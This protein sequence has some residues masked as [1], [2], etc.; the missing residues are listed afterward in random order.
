MGCPS[1][2]MPSG[3]INREH[4]PSTTSLGR[5]GGSRSMTVP[6]IAAP[7]VMRGRRTFIT[8]PQGTESYHGLSCFSKDVLFN[9][10]KP[11][12]LG[13]TLGVEDSDLEHAVADAV[14]SFLTELPAKIQA[15]SGKYGHD[16]RTTATINS[17]LMNTLIPKGVNVQKVNLP[18]I[19]R[20]CARYFRK[21]GQ[22]WY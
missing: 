6:S 13:A 10:L 8:S 11:T 1:A 22:R 14:R 2:S 18:F 16:H 7:T 21:V 19:E 9:A 5:A 20:V 3:S 4:T 15:D 17:M 12:A